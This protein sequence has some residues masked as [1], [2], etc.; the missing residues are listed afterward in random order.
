MSNL[1]DLWPLFGLKLTTPRL[2]LRPASDR[3]LPYVIA[4]AHAGI[5]DPDKSPFS[6]PWTDATGDELTQETLKYFWQCRAALSSR[7]WIIN[8][9]VW[10]DGALAGVQDIMTTDFPD[11]KTI[12]S[13]SWLTMAYQGLG[14]GTEMRAAVLAYAFDYLGAQVAESDGATFNHASLGVSRKLG[15]RDNGMTR[16]AVREREMREQHRIRLDRDGFIRPDWTLR[17]EGHNAAARLLGL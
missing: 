12:K 1:T 4:A 9:G 10:I 7:H 14:I 11:L 3:D 16:V 6:Y 8:F 13:G 15:Y 17:V 5:H 2:E